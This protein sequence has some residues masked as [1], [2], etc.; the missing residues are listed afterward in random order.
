MGCLVEGLAGTAAGFLWI[1]VDGMGRLGGASPAV[2]RLLFGLT[3]FIGC[4]AVIWLL[5][6]NTDSDQRYREREAREI[7]SSVRLG[8][9]TSSICI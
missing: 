9:R 7:R 8:G 5:K 2:P 4:G 1:A 3:G 6:P